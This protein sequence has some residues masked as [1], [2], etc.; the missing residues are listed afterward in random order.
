MRTVI[1]VR[2]IRM[3]I[4]PVIIMVMIRIPTIIIPPI[5]SRVVVIRIVPRIIVPIV[6]IIKGI[7]KYIIERPVRHVPEVGMKSFHSGGITGIVGVVI[8]SHVSSVFLY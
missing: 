7:P 8:I 5:I 1:S 3:V 4:I 6:R 2:S